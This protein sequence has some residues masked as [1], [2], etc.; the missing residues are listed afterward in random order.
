MTEEICKD[1]GINLG[2][3]LRKVFNTPE[4]GEYLKNAIY[5]TRSFIRSHLASA[6]EHAS[7]NW[8]EVPPSL[9]RHITELNKSEHLR[10]DKN[11]YN[12]YKKETKEW[13]QKFSMSYCLYFNLT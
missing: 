4:F 12:E 10:I 11:M 13:L 9:L 7:Q 8:Q 6:Q 1:K 3:H 5:Y 2:F